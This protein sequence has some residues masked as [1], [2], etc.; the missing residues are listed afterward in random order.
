MYLKALRAPKLPTRF[1]IWPGIRVESAIGTGTKDQVRILVASVCLVKD[2]NR[3][4]VLPKNKSYTVNII[5][6]RR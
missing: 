2:T 5:K 3:G 1:R 6:L 4:N